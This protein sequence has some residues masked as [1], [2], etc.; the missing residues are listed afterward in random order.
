[1]TRAKYKPLSN[2]GHS[3]STIYA[4]IIRSSMSCLMFT[5]S[6]SDESFSVLH[7]HFAHDSSLVLTVLRV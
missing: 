3:P 7:S 5:L 4:A 1:M 2:D 6:L